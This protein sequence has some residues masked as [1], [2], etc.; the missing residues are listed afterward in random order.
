MIE[1]PAAIASALRQMNWMSAGA[2]LFQAY[3]TTVLGFGIWSMLMRKYPAATVAPFTLLVPVAGMLRA[4]L[5]RDEPLQW[6]KLAAGLLVLAG[7]ALN[8]FAG[9]MSRSPVTAK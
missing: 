9:R 3:P 1:G 6:W 5:V 4:G 7:L 8:Q 2:V